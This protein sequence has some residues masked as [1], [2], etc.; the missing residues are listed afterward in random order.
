[1]QFEQ[2]KKNVGYRVQLVPEACRLDA[3]GNQ[4]PPM[5][6]DWIIHEVSKDGVRISNLR[7][8]HS[9]TLGLDHIHHFTSNP[10][11]SQGE[12]KY[13]FLTL[14]VQIFLQGN[15]LW[16]RPNGRPGDPVKPQ[17]KQ[18]QQK[19][20]DIAYP[21]AKGIQRSLEGQG[22]R[23]GWCRDMDLPRKLDLEGWEIVVEEDANGI[24]STFHMQDLP[25]NQTLV[26]KRVA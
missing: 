10:D 20:V 17:V 25:C 21:A 18:V 24:R 7:A 22:Y 3:D 26:K 12:I 4:M 15:N 6:D 11:R 14:N 9:T 19:W 2:I 13:G 5:D 1:M 8:H 16:V 23:V